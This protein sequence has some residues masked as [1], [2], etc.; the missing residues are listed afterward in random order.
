[1]LINVE[2]LTFLKYKFGIIKKLNQSFYYYVT[3]LCHINN[4]II[5][6]HFFLFL[7]NLKFFIRK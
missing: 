6:L 3:L 7:I 1:M 4:I 2:H 5:L